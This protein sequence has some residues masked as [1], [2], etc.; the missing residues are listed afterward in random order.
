MSLSWVNVTCIENNEKKKYTMY[1]LSGKSEWKGGGL[2]A[3]SLASSLR[4]PL[5]PGKFYFAKVLPQRHH[6]V[7]RCSNMWTKG[8]VHIPTITL[9]FFMGTITVCLQLEVLTPYP[10]WVSQLKENSTLATCV[11]FPGMETR[12]HN[13]R[14]KWL[15]K[16]KG[17]FQAP[18]YSFVN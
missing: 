4:N 6:L 3:Q 8:A 2:R 16:F 10:G 15:W 5:P 14:A 9:T 17:H 1:L 18:A 12:V 11:K 7:T 13:L